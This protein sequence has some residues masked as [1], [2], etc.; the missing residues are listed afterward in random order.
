[1]NDKD[2]VYTAT[3]HKYRNAAACRYLRELQFSMDRR[4]THKVSCE[5]EGRKKNT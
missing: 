3:K 5:I 4:E 2:S 1:M